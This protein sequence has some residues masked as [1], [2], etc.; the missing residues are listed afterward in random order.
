[1]AR[2]AP[3]GMPV[4]QKPK[5]VDPKLQSVADWLRNEKKSGLHNKEAVQYE[6]RVEYFKG[7]KLVDALTGPRYK[8]KLAKD[9]PI[10]TR[11][12][13]AKLAQE[14]MKIGYIH[15]S[16]R[17]QHAHSRRCEPPASQLPLS[18]ERHAFRCGPHSG[19]SKDNG[20]GSRCRPLAA[21][22]T[23][24]AAAT[25]TATAT[26]TATAAATA[27]AALPST[28]N[29]AHLP[30]TT[31]HPPPLILPTARSSSLTPAPLSLCVCV[32]VRACACV[33]SL[34]QVGAGAAQ[35]A[36]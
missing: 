7:S 17:M 19:G 8:G 14:L 30:P 24:T 10:K 1:M 16:Q 36:V 12:E 13:A 21:T 4:M 31:C 11:A 29:T 22:A 35:H 33:C 15:R 18:E 9:M 27:T 5:E 20:G 2:R 32:C 6:K 26:T 28:H 3:R 25:A 23:A 34:L